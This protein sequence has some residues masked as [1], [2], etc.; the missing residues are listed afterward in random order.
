[1]S[2]FTGP[3]LRPAVIEARE[4]LRAGRERIRQQH[5]SGLAGVLVSTA[6][7]DL[8]DSVILS[9]WEDT[10]AT[11]GEDESV[12]QAVL[13]A[14]GGFGRRDLA[15]YSDVDLMV[16][17]KSG[18]AEALQPVAS[19]FTRDIVDAG[20]QLGF[21]VRTRAEACHWAWKDATVFSSLAESRLL[22]GSVRTYQRYFG[23]LRKG[24]QRRQQRVIDAVETARRE[25]RHKWGETNYLLRPNVKRSRGALRDIQLIRWVG[26]AAYGE[27]ELSRLVRLGDLPEDDYHRVHAAYSF[28]LRLRNELHFSSGKNLDLLDRAAQVEIATHWGYTEHD[29]SLP[30]EW[31]MKDYFEHTRNVRYA[32]AHF[33][34]ATRG[35]PLLTRSLDRVFSKALDEDIRLGPYH[36]WVRDRNLSRFAKDLPSVLRLMDYANRYKRRI[37]HRTWQEIRDA[38]ME[39]AVEPLDLQT[40]QQFMSLLSR[41]GQLP[42][43]LRRLHELRILEK[44]IPAMNRARGM[45]EF[46]Q[47]HKYTV[48]AHSIRAVEA[49]TRFAEE[50]GLAGDVYRGIKDKRLLH[51]ALLMHDLGKGYEEDHCEVGYR[52]AMETCPR[53][54]LD[55]DATET[56]AKLIQLHLEMNNTSSQHDLSDPEIVSQFAATV[57]SMR[58]LDML[59][60]HSL[61]DMT[62]VGPEVLTDWKRRLLVE[63]YV[64]TWRFFD[65]GH[66]P[67]EMDDATESKRET[68]RQRIQA[69]GLPAEV[70]ARG[71][72]VLRSLSALMLQRRDVEPLSKQVIQVAGLAPSSSVSWCRHLPEED[73]AEYT[74]VRVNQSAVRGLFARAAGTLTAQGLGIMR[75]EIATLQPDIAWDTFVVR[76]PEPAESRSLRQA[77]VCRALCEAIDADSPPKLNFPRV[78]KPSTAGGEAVMLLPTRVAFDNETFDRY[79][80]LSLFAY[81]RPGLLYSVAQVLSD[82]STLVHFAK[83]S[84]HL[85]QV[86]DIFYVT[87]LAGNQLTDPAQHERLREALIA[88]AA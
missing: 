27:T 86:M 18:N 6:L 45:L 3:S 25:E 46:N 87:D 36:I 73:A 48:D 34:A 75:A 7:T 77:A 52:I 15:P 17:P 74:L 10:I 22:A 51:L 58:M 79:T 13:V 59:L 88:A 65:S 82:H 2:P 40:G 44:L 50:E 23:A 5:Q 47:Y 57:G 68:I 80:V 24:A 16:V 20:L 41:P 56:V 42:S 76:D 69:A 19:Q 31:F 49:A 53:L 70:A 60:I 12:S 32:V 28:L 26:F 84:T 33:L 85:D 37:A 29:G 72:T 55:A 81:D 61:A 63:L 1:M 43:L 35:H 64:R 54:G 78:W 9:L 30:V 4:R 83:I 71:E 38:M 62:A 11:V 14:H 39:Q 67:G 8:F 21:T 66:L